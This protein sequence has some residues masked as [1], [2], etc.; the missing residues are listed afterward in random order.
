MIKKSLQMF[1]KLLKIMK[2][3]Q[4]LKQEILV[5]YVEFVIKSLET[6]GNESDMN[7]FISKQVNWHQIH[8]VPQ[9]Q[10]YSNQNQEDLQK[11]V[12][13]AQFARKILGTVIKCNDT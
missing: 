7:K 2:I 13:Y 3:F 1:H 5:P 6:N 12:P 9:I 11:A 4:Y 8:Q 10:F